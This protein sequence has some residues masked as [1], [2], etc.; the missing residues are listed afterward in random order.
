MGDRNVECTLA[1][2]NACVTVDTGF[3]GL[4]GS[5]SNPSEALRDLLAPYT[6]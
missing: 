1:R 3:A 5:L 4:M 2:D 6:A